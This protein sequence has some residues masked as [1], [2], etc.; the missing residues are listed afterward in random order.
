MVGITQTSDGRQSRV[1]DGRCIEPVGR[2]CC[3]VKTL[4]RGGRIFPI[5]L[6]C[7]GS[8]ARYALSAVPT[9]EAML[10]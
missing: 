6:T 4:S 10:T 2:S 1:G 9:S 7:V 3:T 8:S 5:H